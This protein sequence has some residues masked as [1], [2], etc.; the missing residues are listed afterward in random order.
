[1]SYRITRD[2]QRVV[3][4]VVPSGGPTG[5][6]SYWGFWIGD[7]G[8]TTDVLVRAQYD[9]AGA[10]VGGTVKTAD[11]SAL[12]GAAWGSTVEFDLSSGFGFLVASIIRAGGD[13]VGH[14]AIAF[15]VFSE[16]GSV[17]MHLVVWDA[18]NGSAYFYTPGQSGTTCR[19]IESTGKIHWLEPELSG[20]NWQVN[21]RSSNRKLSSVSTIG[22]STPQVAAGGAVSIETAVGMMT[23]RDRVAMRNPV[24]QRDV[25]ETIVGNTQCSLW[26]EHSGAI[27]LENFLASGSSPHAIA[28]Q[29]DDDPIFYDVNTKSLIKWTKESD[30]LV[31]SDV[32]PASG[33]WLPEAGWIVASVSGD[34]LEA[35]LYDQFSSPSGGRIIR[36][37]ISGPHG[38]APETDINLAS[39]AASELATARPPDA[40]FIRT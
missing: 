2:L 20:G 38:A 37:P 36:S 26:F 13:G 11:F 19:W 7:A 4:P 24:V 10:L 5:P 18:E 6:A 35:A 29:V 30:P 8:G 28:H 15:Q 14:G 32:W 39:L 23:G 12:F 1:M 3:A 25:F 21:H 40:A 22:N 16:L 17:P 33:T 9:S 31:R 34:G 27:A